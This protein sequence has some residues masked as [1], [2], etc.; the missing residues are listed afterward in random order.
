MRVGDSVW[1][2]KRQNIPNATKATYDEPKEIRTRLN[3]LTVMAASGYIQ[4]MKY[5]EDVDNT[6]IVTA[7]MRA[8]GNEIKEGDLFWVDGESPNAELEE[9]YGNGASANA[10][11]RSVSKGNLMMEVTLMRNKNQLKR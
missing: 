11:V 6:W 4:V 3:Y 1:V 8:F 9:K 5:G 7:N 2:A 10:V